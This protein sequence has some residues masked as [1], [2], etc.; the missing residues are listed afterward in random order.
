MLVV[1]DV[2]N[3]WLVNPPEWA[4]VLCFCR[5]VGLILENVTCG[6]YM[7]LFA[8]GKIGRYQTVE[9]LFGFVSLPFAYLMMLLGCDLFAVGLAIILICIF[10]LVIR[11][12]FSQ[13]CAYLSAQ[14]W[15]LRNF[16]PVI[17]VSCFSLFPGFLIRDYFENPLIRVLMVTLIVNC[18]FVPFV[19]KIVLDAQ[20]RKFVRDYGVKLLRRVKGV[21]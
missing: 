7:A 13:R 10:N 18:V 15:F 8:C 4:G 17:G 6:Q 12:Y 9:A 20:E 11:S 1:D 3:L 19:W 2:L 14:D 21:C 16:V 5:L